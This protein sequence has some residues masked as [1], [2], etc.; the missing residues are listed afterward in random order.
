MVDIFRTNILSFI[1]LGYQWTSF[2]HT[3]L[4]TEGWMSVKR[5][6]LRSKGLPSGSSS[7]SHDLYN[8]I[9]ISYFLLKSF[10]LCKIV[11]LGYM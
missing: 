5:H 3:I 11:I 10:S 1:Q 4:R 7:A 2:A 6:R 8:L 9:E